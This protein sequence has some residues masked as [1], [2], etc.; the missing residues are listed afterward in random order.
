MKNLIQYIHKSSSK[1][2]SKLNLNGIPE[3]ATPDFE[4][5]KDQENFIIDRLNEAYPE[6]EWVSTKNFYGD[7]YNTMLDLVNGDIVGKKD[8]EAVF[9]IDAKVASKNTK[10]LN[11]Y[12]VIN[13]NSI[14]NFGEDNH[15]Y[16]CVNK[17]GSDFIV[18]KSKEIKDL[19]NNTEKC[20]KVSNNEDRDKFI[21]KSLDKYLDKYL[22]K[23]ENV[24]KKDYMPSIIFRN[25]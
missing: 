14:L 2:L 20:L 4:I 9:F 25:N 23:T 5:G 13:L 12:G 21:E 6:Y 22:D 16:L 15:Y 3:S 8:G 17:D 24:S 1:Y 10:K 11:L 19:F 18:K 7:E